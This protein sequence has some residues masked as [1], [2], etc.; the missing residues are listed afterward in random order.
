MS[1][2]IEGLDP[3]PSAAELLRIKAER[4]AKRDRRRNG[5]MTVGQLAEMRPLSFRM[6]THAEE[7]RRELR[8]RIVIG[9]PPIASRYHDRLTLT[10]LF[11]PRT[12]K[13]HG[14][15]FGIKQS[16][17]YQKF[18]N[19]VV[20]HIA[21]HKTALGLPLP[22]RQYNIAAHFFTDNDRADTVGLMQG[23]A[24]ALEDAEVLTDDRQL[25]T[26]NGTDQSLDQTHPRVEL[27]I[28]PIE[29]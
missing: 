3:M 12:K 21:A 26:W 4:E 22:E 23:L 27:T 19:A 9:D 6:L 17:G 8:E 20:A 24:D 1:R 13:N 5:T 18:R 14:Q 7:D 25:R 15:S 2:R 10:L 16:V 29:P 28:T 11:A